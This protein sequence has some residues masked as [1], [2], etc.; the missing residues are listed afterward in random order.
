MLRPYL[1]TSLTQPLTRMRGGGKLVIPLD[2]FTFVVILGK[3][4]F[5]IGLCKM[6]SLES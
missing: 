2:H 4:N 3:Q 5:P 1:K 6:G